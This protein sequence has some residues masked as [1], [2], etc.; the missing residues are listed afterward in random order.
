MVRL[1]SHRGNISGPN[2]QY[3]NM[4]PTIE[5]ALGRGFDVEID[6]WKLPDEDNFFRLGHDKP[7]MHQSV[8][9]SYLQNPNLLV[10]CK[11]D[12]AW[13]TLKNDPLVHCFKQTEED[14]VETSKQFVVVH[15]R[16]SPGVFRTSFP[17]EDMKNSYNGF[18][19]TWF[20]DRSKGSFWRLETYDHD[21]GI[22]SDYI[23]SYR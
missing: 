14:W 20:V 18:I 7:M 21:F 8:N 3:E 16:F 6:V 11:N 9:T 19:Y 1:I 10:H 23:E 4:F 12:L 17:F 13:E 5:Y 22:C 2:T 15:S